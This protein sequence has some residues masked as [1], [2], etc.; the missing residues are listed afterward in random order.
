MGEIP[1]SLSSFLIDTT[2]KDPDLGGLGD[3]T[4][5]HLR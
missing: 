5:S 2:S 4:S 3:E 1:P